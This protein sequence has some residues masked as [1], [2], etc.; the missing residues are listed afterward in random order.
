[1][2]YR[3]HIYAILHGQSETCIS[4]DNGDVDATT[5]QIHD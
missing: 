4:L 3:M 5:P 2:T 1:M